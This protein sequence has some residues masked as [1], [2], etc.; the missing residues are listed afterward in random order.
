VHCV[1]CMVLIIRY[2]YFF[3]QAEDG[4]R[5]FRVTGVQTCALPILFGEAGPLMMRAGTGG[6]VD[7]RN[8][9][10]AHFLDQSEA[11]WLWM[12]DTDME[13]G[14]ATCRERVWNSEGTDR[15]EDKI[16]VICVVTVHA[17]GDTVL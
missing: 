9:I 11:E 13:I 1:N 16:R 14:R 3:F 5:V 6:L 7:A 12:V 17:W 2:F 8:R 15:S 10:M 4:I